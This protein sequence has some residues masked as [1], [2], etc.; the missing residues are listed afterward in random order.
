MP[1]DTRLF[2][3]IAASLRQFRRADLGDFIVDVGENPVDATYV[4]PLPDDA[5][6]QMMLSGNTT[7]IL[8]RKGTGKSTIFAKAQSVIRRQNQS[9]SIY[10]D[11]KSLY[12]LL[13]ADD[14]AVE[15]VQ[16]ATIQPAVLQAHRLR[17]AFL[18]AVL[19]DLVK[20]IESSFDR[21]SLY[22]RW[23]GKRRGYDDLRANLERLRG[24]VRSGALTEAEL[25]ILQTISVKAKDRAQETGREEHKASVTG[26]LSLSGLSASG[27][28]TEAAFE[29][30]LSDKQIY[31]SYSDA[32][33]RSFPFADLISQIRD[34]LEEIGMKRLVVF[35]DD[36][37]ELSW[38]NQR[39]FVDV[40]LAPLNNSSGDNIKLK[41]AAYPGRVYY[42]TIDPGK[43]D[44]LNL[45]FDVLYKNQDLQTTEAA[46][47][48]Y[49][50]RLVQQ[51]FEAFGSNVETYLE[52]SFP[53]A[54]FMRL[55]FETSFNVPRLM[56]Y[57]LHYC[58]LDR[59]SQ[60]LPITA[61]AVRLAAQKYYDQVLVRYFDRMNRF[62]LE[63]FERKLDRRNQ[64][65][66]LRMIIDEAKLVRRRIYSGDVG[67]DYF[68][69]LK[70]PP[71][72]H[73][74]VSPGLEKILSGLEMNF[75]IS[76]YHTLRDK[77]RK[78]V[79]IYALHYGL[80]E[81]ERLGWGY[82]RERRLDRN[83]FIQ[84]CFNFNFAVQQFL[85]QRQ[86]IRCREC[87]ASFGLDEQKSLERYGWLCP[88]CRNGTCEVVN[89]GEDMKV[90]IAA[91]D[92]ATM[93]P[94]IELDILSTLQEEQRDMRA[95]EIALL[96]DTDYRLAGRRT[97]K[98]RDA[99]LVKKEEV[100]GHMRNSIS[101]KGQA[102]YFGG[103]DLDRREES[104][105][106]IGEQDVS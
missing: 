58:Y 59:V 29:E 100:G 57:I 17:K 30:T 33:L 15:N 73:F 42:G 16:Q 26:K 54:D 74:A 6:L 75:L 40:I 44:T 66:L 14:A 94:P 11:V 27:Q 45:D 47:I 68:K 37:S 1:L 28:V 92:R 86:T 62:A 67:G 97:S 3:R 55:M 106:E 24:Q 4:D 13:S 69:D 83:Y 72:S 81:S 25:P 79:H 87:Q 50:T 48:D 76:K 41:V 104:D 101:P 7:F 2:S 20:E 84:R 53:V 89:L 34:L 31:Q 88:E 21:L 60:N 22:D 36:F 18:G 39:L 32:V 65:D 38:L 61:T 96:V 71:V 77:D 8:G 98:L 105:V 49:T 46:A 35:F 52:R 56:G 64:Y 19:A 43:I 93:L 85:E 82:P 51:R 10:V 12:D 23:L 95:K 102:I 78:E 103:D 91:L 90:E 5:V 99:G 9:L 80:T 70:N 63:P